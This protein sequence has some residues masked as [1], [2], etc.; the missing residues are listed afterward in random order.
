MKNKL[1]TYTPDHLDLLRE[2]FYSEL[3]YAGDGRRKINIGLNLFY[4][5]PAENT[6]QW[7]LG[8]RDGVKKPVGKTKKGELKLE[9]I[10]SKEFKALSVQPIIDAA[11]VKASVI[12]KK[13]VGLYQG[14]NFNKTII[15]EAPPFLLS[16][17]ETSA[18]FVAEFILDNSCTSPYAKAITSCFN[19]PDN[20]PIMDTLR[21]NCCGFFDV[22]PIPLPINSDLRNLWATDERYLID[23]KR[24]FVHF[25]E[26]AVEKYLSQASVVTTCPHQLAVGIPLNNAIT[27]YEHYAANGPL[28]F[29]GVH[30]DFNA[31]HS[32]PFSDKKVGLWIH[33]YKNCIISSSNTPTADLMKLAFG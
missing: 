28:E 29:N 8:F 21:A 26:W 30:I 7:K 2:I 20:T 1:P 11:L 16:I 31:P 6:E 12:K 14:S 23:G 4:G 13:L 22:I 3:E 5:Y 33:A 32:I 18:D 25:F 9:G 17:H 24:I 27:L 10:P 19:A 15:Y